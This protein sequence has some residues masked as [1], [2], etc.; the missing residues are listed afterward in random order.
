MA[1]W[2]EDH[3]LLLFDVRAN[4]FLR[5]MVRALVSTMMH[6]ARGKYTLSHFEELLHS[7]EI[8]QA[9]FSAPGHG[10]FLKSV[11]YPTN[12]LVQPICR[13]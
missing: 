10:L 9:D 11:E 13:F 4:R 1:R 7:P 5:G 8:A 6:T 3:N 12:L 2:V